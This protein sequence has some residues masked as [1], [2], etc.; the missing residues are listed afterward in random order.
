MGV[1]ISEFIPFQLSF[2]LLI[3]KN[4]IPYITMPLVDTQDLMILRH[5]SGV[6]TSSKA[7]LVPRVATKFILAAPPG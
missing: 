6:D 7:W 4:N 1:I 5:Q 2:L 3:K